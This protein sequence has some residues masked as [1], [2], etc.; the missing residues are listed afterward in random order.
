MKTPFIIKFD[1]THSL[2]GFGYFTANMLNIIHLAKTKRKC[3][4]FGYLKQKRKCYS[5]GYLK[6]SV[7]V[8]HIIHSKTKRKCL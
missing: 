2:I 8:I 4:S 3:Y 6:Q 7:N 5:F 1:N